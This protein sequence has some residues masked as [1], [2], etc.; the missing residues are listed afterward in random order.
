LLLFIQKT[1]ALF[2]ALVVLGF[3]PANH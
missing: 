3:V 1:L 2:T